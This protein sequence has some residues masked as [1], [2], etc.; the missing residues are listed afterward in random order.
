MPVARKM[1]ILREDG[2][3]PTL[4]ESLA[5]NEAQLQ[6]LLK[7]NADLLPV[8]EFG[9]TGPLMVV[10]RETTLP[11]GSIDLVAIA[12]GGDILIIEFKTGPQNTDFR[13][14]LA[15]LLDYGSDL[16]RLTSDQFETTVAARYFASAHCQDDR[17]RG[18]TTLLGAARATWPDLSEE[19]T[20]LFQEHLAEQLKAGGFHYVV[21]AQRFSH[22]IE[23]T[24][25][26]LNA[27]MPSAR[28]YAVEIVKF[29][30][31]GLSAFESRTVIKP[32]PRSTIRTV[33]S[34]NETAFLESLG[35]DTYRSTLHE[36]FELARSLGL[37]LE[38]GTRGT[39]LRLPV[40]DRSEPLTIARVFPGGGIG[41]MGL[42]DLTLGFDTTSAD[43]TPSVASSLE[44]YLGQVATLPD[45]EAV[46]VR[47][48]RGYHLP[49]TAVVRSL[50]Q[51]AEILASLVAQ[52]NSES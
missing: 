46:K 41:W 51:I 24:V 1:I 49:P 32:S 45:A 47:N 3:R 31:D 5:D 20:D 13:Q 36:L 11:S 34:V 19:E 21:V 25:E 8:D 28:F 9:M 40:P 16:W 18:K 52:V 12:R 4:T 38:W 42:S 2:S 15:Q 22:T 27:A 33:G 10:G 17:L 48:L 7:N 6:N 43:K 14:V 29:S 39:S 23:R 26:Y 30:A 44:D 35:D 50:P 37:R